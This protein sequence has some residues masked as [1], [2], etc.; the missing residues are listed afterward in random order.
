MKIV[1]IQFSNR[2]IWMIKRAFWS[3]YRITEFFQI[4]HA[5]DIKWAHLWRKLKEN[6]F[7]TATREAKFRK[8]SFTPKG[9]RRCSSCPSRLGLTKL[10]LDSAISTDKNISSNKTVVILALS[11]Q[12]LARPSLAELDEHRLAPF[13]L[14]VPSQRLTQSARGVQTYVVS[15]QTKMP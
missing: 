2:T 7:D 9:S 5:I 3:S 11:N 8:S 13:G 6:G 15:L 1:L 12:A 4:L 10:W 14:S